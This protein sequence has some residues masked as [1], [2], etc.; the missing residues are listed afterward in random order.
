MA[1]L[2]SSSPN[3]SLFF[4]FSIINKFGAKLNSDSAVVSWELFVVI[5]KEATEAHINR[6]TNSTI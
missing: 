2:L 1:K 6:S 3:L 4:F 5:A